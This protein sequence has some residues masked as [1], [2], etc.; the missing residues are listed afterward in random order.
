MLALLMLIGFAACASDTEGETETTTAAA[1]IITSEPV[2]ETTVEPSEVFDVPE[3]LD[4]G[5]VTF[6]ILACDE[7]VDFTYFEDVEE[8]SGTPMNDAIYQRNR[9]TEDYLGI[10][11]NVINV[12]GTGTYDSIHTD[13]LSGDVRYDMVSPHI[14]QSVAPMV[15][16]GYVLDLGDLDYLDFTKS[17]WN[18]GFVDT[19][20]IKGK[21]FYASGDLIA[22]NA[23][24]IVFNKTML[25]NNGLPDMYET[26]GS[27]EWTLDTMGS[28]TAN[29]YYDL[30]GDGTMSALDQYAFSD[31]SNTGLST[32]FVHA[33]GML[34]VEK[35]GDGFR[36]TLGDE[37]MYSILDKL[38]TYLYRDGNN[39]IKND[40]FGEGRVLF[41]SQ[42]LLKLQILRDYSTDFGIIPFPKYSQEQEDYYSSVWNGLVC[43]PV[44]AKD[45][46]MSGAVM[47][48]LAY[49]SQQTV[50]PAYYENLLGGK[51][52]TDSES[53]EMLDTIFGGLVYDIGL[54]YDNFTGNY[55]SLGKLLNQ[56]ST[57]LTSWFKTYKSIFTKHYQKLF[58][59]V[60]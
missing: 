4:Y 58:D 10:K 52:A 5:D 17:W 30:D 47:E 44:T 23:R 14:I 39:T 57:D 21:T 48:T 56:G 13:V 9:M 42:V 15:L 26:V 7:N 25:E 8:E 34:F 12:N 41:G 43:V 53:V 51:F 55:S 20:S 29:I 60:G 11:I 38:Y 59:S 18:D 46:D 36:L 31:L 2:D 40:S 22:P 50:V 19:M 16:E 3:E 54:C 49:Y 33:S 37:K 32:S 1:E 28:Y 24:V 35:E 45:P 6:N 27:G